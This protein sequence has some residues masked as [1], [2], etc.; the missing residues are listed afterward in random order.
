MEKKCLM[1]GKQITLKNIV[2]CT[3]NTDLKKCKRI[4]YKVQR[5]W[6][7]NARKYGKAADA[8]KRKFAI[9]FMVDKASWAALQKKKK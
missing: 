5:K 3:K 6:Q 9:I 1:I 4:F 7:H 8:G 2:G